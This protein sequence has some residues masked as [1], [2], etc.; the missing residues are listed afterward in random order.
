[1]STSTVPLFGH[2]YDLT[3][4]FLDGSDDLTL[5]S[6]DWEPEALR[7]TFD[8]NQT[9]YQ[10]T[11][12]AEIC[13]YNLN[14]KTNKQLLVTQ[15]A[16]VTLNAG[17]QTG[18]N[19]G[20]IFSGIVLRAMF[21]KQNVTDY[22][23]TMQCITGMQ[24]FLNAVVNFA[25]GP[26]Q[27]QAQLIAQIAQN[28][29]HP[30]QVGTTSPLLETQR[31]PC[32]KILFGAPKFYIEQMARHHNL[33]WTATQSGLFIQN[34]DLSEP[35]PDLIY[36]PAIP[37][38][39]DITQPDPSITYSIQGTPQQVDQGVV[40]RVMLDARL[41]IS[42]PPQGVK[43]DNKVVRQQPVAIGVFPPILSQDGIFAVIG[44]RHIGDSRGNEWTSEIHGIITTAQKAIFGKAGTQ[45]LRNANTNPSGVSNPNGN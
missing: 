1:M 38:G 20:L 4:S 6:D 41:Q 28:A 9:G 5:S 27:T 21:E 30:F 40:F 43:I 18:S 22:K 17:Y 15:G 31:L 32:P 13:V 12:D 42:I 37:P 45:D 36:S 2:K 44:I 16:V 39:D 29:S 19:Y 3:I 33:T 24:Q 23:L 14:D 8:I 25:S 7:F 10:A 34:L 26:F 11:W 35:N